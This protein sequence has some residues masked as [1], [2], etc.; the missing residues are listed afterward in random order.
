MP[1]TNIAL[2]VSGQSVFFPS[3]RL[4]RRLVKNNILYKLPQGTNVGL[5]LNRS[6]QSFIITGFFHDDDFKKEYT[7]LK[8]FEQCRVL[9]F[10]SKKKMVLCH[11]ALSTLP[12]K[13]VAIESFR[14]R[15]ISGEGDR[16]SYTLTLV[17]ADFYNTSLSETVS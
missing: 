1:D 10:L 3:A 11:L 8:A 5:D 13:Q 9:H 12:Q 17:K 14:F 15:K 7:G 2:I 6:K 16:C 4:Q